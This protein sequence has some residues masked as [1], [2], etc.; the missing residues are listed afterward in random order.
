MSFTDADDGGGAK[1]SWVKSLVDIVLSR[2]A[3]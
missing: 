1:S 3:V 2:V